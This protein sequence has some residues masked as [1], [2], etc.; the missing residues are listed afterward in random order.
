MYAATVLLFCFAALSAGYTIA[1]PDYGADVVRADPSNVEKREFIEMVDIEKLMMV[2]VGYVDNEAVRDL[3]TME[4]SSLLKR[5]LK[6]LAEFDEFKK[7]IEY[8]ESKGYN[9][10][11]ISDYLNSY[12]NSSLKKHEY[13]E[14]ERSPEEARFVEILNTEEF[15]EMFKKLL[16]KIKEVLDTFSW[17][18][19]QNVC[20]LMKKIFGDKI[21]T[22]VC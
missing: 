11:F 16:E 18:L 17:T 12:L 21:P 6:R 15:I 14:S 9:L 19:F 7:I 20:E 5:I 22:S 1:A 13:F 10:Q 2:T 4:R 3:F 8:L